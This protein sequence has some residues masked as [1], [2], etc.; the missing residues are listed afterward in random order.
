MIQKK[1][2]YDHHNK[3]IE[4]S[5]WFTD[6]SEALDTVVFLGTVQIG[7]LPEWVAEACPPRTAIVQ[8]AP[9]WHAKDDGSDIPEYM[10]GFTESVL[11]N[12]RAHY[13]FNSLH[14]IADSQAVPG[15]MQLF[16]LDRYR[17]YLNNAVLLQPL[18]LT[19]NVFEGEDD[20]R[21]ELFRK[22][23][24]KNA[25]HQLTS[26]FLDSRLRYNHHL[27]SKTV[28][29]R[30]PKARAQYSAGLMH[31]ALPDLKRLLLQGN[32]ITIICGANDKIFPAS[33]V[34]ANLKAENITVPVLEVKDVPHSPLATK[35]GIKLLN[36]AF[37]VLGL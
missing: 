14:V 13:T 27:L 32:N 23:I 3:Q 16:A 12:I 19:T 31:N 1:F 15:V 9:H 36:S 29:F 4:Y 18:G 7:K 35:Q 22:R 20:V 11:K 5:V 33:E 17:S 8:G 28:S 24:I 30:D 6:N 21:I 34:Q 2:V 25:Y 10:A 37:S 26:L